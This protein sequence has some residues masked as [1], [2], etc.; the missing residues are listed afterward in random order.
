MAMKLIRKEDITSPPIIRALIMKHGFLDF[1]Q[2]VQDS[3]DPLLLLHDMSMEAGDLQTAAMSS[4]VYTVHYMFSGLPLAPLCG[5]LRLFIAQLTRYQQHAQVSI[6]RIYRQCILNLMGDNDNPVFLS[7][8]AMDQ[9]EMLKYLGETH[10]NAAIL[11]LRNIRMTLGYFF[12]DFDLAG[13]MSDLIFS[14]PLQLAAR[15][16][17]V[18]LCYF[19]GGLTAIALSEKGLK[20][21]R[22]MMRAQKII[23]LFEKMVSVGAVNCHH[24]LLFLRA[25]AASM[26]EKDPE[27]VRRAFDKAIASASR[28]GFVHHAALANERVGMF[29]LGR[30][31]NEWGEFY[32][33]RAYQLYMEWGAIAKVDQLRELYGFLSRVRDDASGLNRSCFVKGRAR[34]NRGNAAKHN[35]ELL[36]EFLSGSQSSKSGESLAA[37]QILIRQ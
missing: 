27:V 5:D 8:S 6:C 20:R 18:M 15:N 29:F 13:E 22:Y 1:T 14:D 36:R 19:F 10:N 26:K 37:K 32:L 9:E 33:R 16:S 17:H 24:M 31:D 34:F 28:S 35:G 7:G 4:V 2:P 3:I 11:I 30:N 25:E 23:K 21:M 12:R